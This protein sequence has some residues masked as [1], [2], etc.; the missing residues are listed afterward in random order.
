[1]L[2]EKAKDPKKDPPTTPAEEKLTLR[3]HHPFQTPSEPS[4]ID[5]QDKYLLKKGEECLSRYIGGAI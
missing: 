3:F 1:V 2:K 5:G 4:V